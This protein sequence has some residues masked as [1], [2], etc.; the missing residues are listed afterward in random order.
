MEG[1]DDGSGRKEREMHTELLGDLKRAS[2]C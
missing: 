2:A 1:L